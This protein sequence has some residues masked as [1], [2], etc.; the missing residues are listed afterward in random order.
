MNSLPKAE[1]LA[2]IKAKLSVIAPKFVKPFE[3]DF[4]TVSLK[5][6]LDNKIVRREKN[7]RF[8]PKRRTLGND[9]IAD[10]EKWPYQHKNF[11]KQNFAEKVQEQNLVIDEEPKPE[12]Q[13]KSGAN[14]KLP[15][16][17]LS[18]AGSP[19]LGSPIATSSQ[20][21]RPSVI[22]STPR[23]PKNEQ[24]MYLKAKLQSIKKKAK[25]DKTAN[26]QE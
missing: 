15:E 5:A 20:K 16:V 10:L 6:H 26:A 17:K 22:V 3:I 9:Y 4:T 7:H 1:N 11:R 19:I 14:D 18:K 8:K 2:D 24:A 13:I 25:L 21:M 12:Q 23:K